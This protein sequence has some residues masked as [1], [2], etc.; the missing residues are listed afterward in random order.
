MGAELTLAMPLWVLPWA[1]SVFLKEKHWGEKGRSHR[2][3]LAMR[4]S[5][6]GFL[7]PVVWKEQD[8]SAFFL[9][10]LGLVWVY[11]CTFL[12]HSL[13][14]WWYH[15]APVHPGEARVTH[16]PAAGVASTTRT[17]TR[18]RPWPCRP[19][20]TTGLLLTTAKSYLQ[21]M[22]ADPTPSFCS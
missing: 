2:N 15:I 16:R 6:L 14:H 10:N 19:Q 13:H 22:H 11:F 7:S 1:A 3:V 20:G 9:L 8:V 18:P 4:S 5:W 12:H 17:R 21:A